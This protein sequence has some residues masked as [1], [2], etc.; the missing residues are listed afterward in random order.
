M[1]DAGPVVLGLDV[2]TT[3]TKAVVVDESGA[4]VGRA[5]VPT[6]FTCGERVEMDVDALRGC[7]AEVLGALGGVRARVAGVGVAGLAESGAPLDRSGRPLAPIVGWHDP[8]GQEAVD[9]LERR[10]GPDLELRIGQRLRPILTA[11]KLGWLVEHGLAGAVRWLGVPELVVHALTGAEATERSLAARTG[12]YDVGAL[13][14]MPEVGHVLG[15]DVSVF[16]PI[17]RAG[18]VVGRTSEAGAR[19]SGLPAG[20]PVT[21]AGH[22][23]LTGMVGA[24]VGPGEV[25][26]SVGTA[27]TLV[28]R[29]ATLPDVAA[30]GPVRVAVTLHPD[31]ESWAALVSA[32]RSGVVLEAAVRRLGLPPAEL[33]AAA[34]GASPADVGDAVDRLLAG[35]EAELDRDRAGEVWAGLLRAL[36]GRTADAYRRLEQVLGPADKVVVFGGGSVSDPWLKAKEAAL[37]VPLRRAP[38]TDAVGRGAA[39]Y[40]GVAAGWW[41]APVGA[42]RGPSQD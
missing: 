8:R 16:P 10:L 32:V 36:A 24:G 41:P 38:V 28:A 1:A 29:W 18:A 20:I 3:G 9:E 11:A 23:H 7:V 6:P 2:G 15:F 19:W 21:L 14:W 30:A 25:G 37:P 42:Q 26:N 39:L 34:A 17:E 13:E 33:D 12:C 40:G 35:E 5:A 4:E 22:D 31:G 27:E